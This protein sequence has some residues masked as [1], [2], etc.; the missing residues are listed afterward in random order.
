L[1]WHHLSKKLEELDPCWA[2]HVIRVEEIV[3]L[4]L[5]GWGYQW[6]SVPRAYANH[7]HRKVDEHVPIHVADEGALPLV[8]DEL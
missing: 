2:G 5:Q 6:M 3:K 8:K 4:T 1:F 7:A